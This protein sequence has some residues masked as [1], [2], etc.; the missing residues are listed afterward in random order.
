M[1]SITLVL[2]LLFLTAF[3][4]LSFMNQVEKTRIGMFQKDWTPD[5]NSQ[6]ANMTTAQLK[7]LVSV[8]PPQKTALRSDIASVTAYVPSGGPS[9]AFD[10]SLFAS[11]IQESLGSNTADLVTARNSSSNKNNTSY[12][13]TKPTNNTT[14][15]TTKPTN[16]T[17]NTTNTT[18]TNTT[19]D[20][21]TK[22]SKCIGAVR[23]QGTCGSCWAFA[24]VE[25]FEDRLCIAGK[26]SPLV[27]RSTQYLLDCDSAQQGCNG[28]YPNSAWAFL[29]K[30][31]APSEACYPY[32]GAKKS[33]PSKC[34]N[35]SAITT[36]KAAA[37]VTY[38]SVAAVQADIQAKGPVETYFMVYEDFYYY[39]TGIYTPT[40]SVQVGYHAVK[41]IGFGIDSKSGNYWIVQ[42]SWG[43][44]WGESGYFK[45]KAG[46]CEFDTLDHFVAGTV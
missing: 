11:N 38:S 42:N 40:T 32:K 19:F 43:T 2:S 24:T 17:T 30:N 41:V 14:N 18:T 12:N 16:N 35:G 1:K 23:N 44:T 34:A 4:D 9:K 46:T 20:G 27:Q 15:N 31:G 7:Q 13:T 37:V 6:F 22:W 25:A 10:L 28:G 45:I 39:K 21:R 3:C 5:I 29:V 8:L 33:C 36:N 26:V